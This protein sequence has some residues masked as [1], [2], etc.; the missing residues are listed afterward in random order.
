M[1]TQALR[2]AVRLC[3]TTQA[4]RRAVRLLGKFFHLR[5]EH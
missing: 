1:T 3:M 5:A 2:R 4:L